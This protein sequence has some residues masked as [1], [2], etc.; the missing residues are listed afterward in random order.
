MDE[1]NNKAVRKVMLSYRD[2]GWCMKR[3]ETLD[4][5]EQCLE[6]MMFFYK[7]LPAV[8]AELVNSDPDTRMYLIAHA[9]WTD[10]DTD[11]F[12]K[13]MQT[14]LVPTAQENE[15]LKDHEPP[16]DIRRRLAILDPVEPGYPKENVS[17]HFC[18]EPPWKNGYPT[19]IWVVDH[20]WE[21]HKLSLRENEVEAFISSHETILTP[22]YVEQV[23]DDTLPF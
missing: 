7:N 22:S 20:D 4:V 10:L 13:L 1:K 15:L 17:I 5:Y 12:F 21:A 16:E 19:P 18:S 11:W 8:I 23:E 6:R 14:I 3:G 2:M 9:V